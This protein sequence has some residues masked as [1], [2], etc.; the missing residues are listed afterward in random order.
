MEAGQLEEGKADRQT[1]RQTEE[2]E[3]QMAHLC[4]TSHTYCS[5]NPPPRL[6]FPNLFYPK[7]IT[8]V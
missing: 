5:L 2:E 6:L 3:E 1:D 4:Y 7:G 8:Y